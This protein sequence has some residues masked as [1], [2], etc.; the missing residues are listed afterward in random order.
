MS[1]H[2]RTDTEWAKT[3]YNALKNDVDK[4]PRGFLNSDQVAREMGVERTQ[5]L[6]MLK[7]L[8]ERGLVEVRHF[9]AVVNEEYGIVRKVAHYKL[10]KKVR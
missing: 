7:K 4:I 2:R 10:I 5:A 3:L 6:K 1:I 9:R 8:R